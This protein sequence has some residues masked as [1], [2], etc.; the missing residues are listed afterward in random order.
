MNITFLDFDDIKNPLLSAGQAH[1]TFEVGRRLVQKG[2]KVKVISSKYPGF[3]DRVE[4]GI[5][6]RHIGVGTNNIRLNNF[7]YIFFIPFAVRKL[8]A[9]IIIECFTAPISTLF[10]PLFSKIPVIGL[11]SMFNAKEFTKKYCLP[12]KPTQSYLFDQMG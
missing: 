7:L 1:A 12:F 6:Y 3:K 9:D 4:E 2:H 5:E 11:P 10:S 8:K